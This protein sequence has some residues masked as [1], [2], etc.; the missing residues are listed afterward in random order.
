VNAWGFG[1]W[2]EG[3]KGSGTTKGPVCNNGVEIKRLARSLPRSNVRSLAPELA[4]S[5]AR[6]LALTGTRS[7]A[8]S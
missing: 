4:C 3:R 2:D 6:S 5:L 8:R 1:V 7:I